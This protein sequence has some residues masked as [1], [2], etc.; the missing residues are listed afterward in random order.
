MRWAA[1]ALMLMLGACSRA[2]YAP[3]LVQPGHIDL[4]RGPDGNS[5]LIDTQQGLVVVD[6]GRHPEHAAAILD[7]ARKVG[8][9]IAAI[10]N[11]HWHLDHS[12]GNS[13]IR[14][15]FPQAKVFASSAIEG[16]LDGFLARGREAARKALRDPAMKPEERAVILR[17]LAVQDARAPLLPTNPV[18]GDQTVTFG[19]RSIQL[20]LAHAAVTEADV[21]LVVPDEKLAIVGDLVVGPVPF[22]DTACEEG[23]SRALGAIGAAKWDRLIPGHGAEMTRADFARWR[24]AFTAF[25]TCAQSDR[26]ADACADLWEEQAKGFYTPAEQDSVRLL[27]RYYVTEVLR[28][29]A[30]QRMAYCR[31][32]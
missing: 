6:T 25:L 3:T 22:F 4:S 23:W 17:S 29:P 15:A 27:T 16:A 9:P 12:T 13:E 2:A 8:K 21:W 20:H 30:S 7:H 1:I 5:E 10:I 28:A 32:R 31:H 24:I 14:A 18:V 19:N 26:S 11:T